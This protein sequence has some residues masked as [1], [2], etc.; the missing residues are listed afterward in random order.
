MLKKRGYIKL[1]GLAFIL[2]C[3]FSVT[4][5]LA[6]DDFRGRITYEITYEGSQIDLAEMEQ[7]PAKAELTVNGP[8][9]RWEMKAGELN[10]IKITNAEQQSVSTKLEI[11]DEHYVIHQ[12][13]YDIQDELSEMIQPEFEFTDEYKEILGYECRKVIATARDQYGER[14]TFEIYYTEE[15]DG[16]PFHFDHPYNEIPGLMLRY[17]IQSGPLRMQYKATSIRSRLFVGR[18]NFR[19]PDKYQP[20]TFEEL[21]AKLRGVF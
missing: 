6:G 12:N 14:V 7:L 13:R 20:T 19:I 2:L 5:A 21:Q 3:L 16:F 18:R 10:Q 8:N 1:S 17:E 11:G 9:V 4:S 15:I